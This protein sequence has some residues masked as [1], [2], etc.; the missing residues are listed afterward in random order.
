[1][2]NSQCSIIIN[3]CCQQR[4]TVHKS[5]FETQVNEKSLWFDV[6][7]CLVI[8]FESIALLEPNRNVA[9]SLILI[10]GDEKTLEPALCL[11]PSSL[12]SLKIDF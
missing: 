5:S 11:V 9:T 3:G 7:V 6:T 8:S 12:L 4:I 1:M 2:I 10:P